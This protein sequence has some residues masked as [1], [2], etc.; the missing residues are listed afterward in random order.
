MRAT[1]LRIESFRG[2][3]RLDLDLDEFTVL[4]GENNTGKTTVLDALRICLRDIGPRR[5]IVFDALDFRLAGATSEPATADPILIEVT[6]SEQTDGEWGDVLV[7][8]LNRSNILQVDD[9]GRGRVILRVTC[10]HDPASRDFAQTWAFLNL[11]RQ[12]LQGIGE[13]ALAMFQRELSYFY[14]QALRDAQHHFGDKGPFWRPFLKDSRLPDKTKA[15]IERRLQEVNELVVNSHGS[16]ERVCDGLCRVQQ[17]VP[18]AAGDGD[19]VS[20]EA[21]PGRIFDM[22]ANARVNLGT[23]DGA[24]I[25]VGRHGEGTQ[26][27]A[28]LMLFAAFLEAWPEGA[29]ILAL[30]EP[31]AHLHPSAIRALCRLV[32]GFSGQKLLS[33]HSGDLL[34]ETEVHQI[35]RLARTNEGVQCFQVPDGLLSDE[36][37]RKFNHHIR[38]SHGDLLFARCWLLVE[39]ESESWIYPAAAR[40]MNVDLHRES[41][42]VVEYKH[43]G[44]VVLA[45]VASA[46]GI[47]WY[48]VGDDD[49]EGANTKRALR[50]H[51]E[52]DGEAEGRVV[53]PYD[54]IEVHL[55]ENGYEDIYARFMLEQNR[56]KIKTPPDDPAYW[57]EYAKFLKKNKT[58]AAAA[59]AA[60]MEE[61]GE[62]GVSKAMQAVIEE[63]VSLAR[64]A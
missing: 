45:K 57:R 2:I 43:S 39:G 13:R 20:I 22:L 28:V 58:R 38:R 42:S 33:T 62:A 53:L 19:V 25:P 17:V 52:D 48:C 49:G 34:A 5:R 12:P 56:A 50:C 21:V 55:L 3:K 51:F 36:E 14:L 24:K 64:G 35:R 60:E 26:S 11:D 18:L 27:L 10:Q 44:V 63:V 31:E 1:A 16:F 40:A 15:E 23:P 4:I 32:G 29:P 59:V 41:I 47:A 6:F 9:A 30:E 7:G 37:R 46:L 54:N 8:R 61:R